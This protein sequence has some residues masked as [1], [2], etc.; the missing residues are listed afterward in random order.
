[1]DGSV[2]QIGEPSEGLLR[3]WPVPAS[4]A[5][6]NYGYAFQWWALCAVIF[7]LYV[8]FQFIAPRRR[9]RPHA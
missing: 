3:D 4:G 5:D 2:V 1:M 9:A 8:W 6:K 7:I